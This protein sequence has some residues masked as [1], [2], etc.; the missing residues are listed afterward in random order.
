MKSKF[1]LVDNCFTHLTGGN[2]GYSVHG[3]ESKHIE[4]VSDFSADETFY[5]DQTI[6][7]AFTDGISGTKY[8]WI[9]ESKF[10]IPG[11]SE[12]I[13]S[14]LEEYFNVFKYIFTHDKELFSLDP[15]FKWC[16]AQGF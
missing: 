12:R 2:M 1:N 9:L 11:I 7:Q 6:D 16:P 5:V 8:A 13:K 14:N 10:V 3:K 4:W 15:R